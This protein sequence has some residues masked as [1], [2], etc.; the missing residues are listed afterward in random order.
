MERIEAV[1]LLFPV[2]LGFDAFKRAIDGPTTDP[3][4]LGSAGDILV[5]LLLLLLLLRGLVD[6][7]LE[8]IALL[9]K[10]LRTVELR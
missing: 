1:D 2:I 10:L 3:F 6:K 7:G 5:S 4:T 9:G 8:L